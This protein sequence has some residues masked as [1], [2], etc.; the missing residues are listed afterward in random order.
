M[1]GSCMCVCGSMP[2]GMTN[3]PPASTTSQRAGAAMP[4]A[5]FHDLA[6]R[7]QDVGPVGLIGRDDGAALDE[8]RHFDHLDVSSRNGGARYARLATDCATADFCMLHRLPR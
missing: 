2:P 5:D 3:W 8:Y 7:A 4:V 6:I 1:N